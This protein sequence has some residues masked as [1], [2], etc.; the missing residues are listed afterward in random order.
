MNKE[1]VLLIQKKL[2]KKLLPLSQASSPYLYPPGTGFR[3]FSMFDV[4]DAIRELSDPVMSEEEFNEIA[5]GVSA[6]LQ[7]EIDSK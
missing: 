2:M 6:E 3:T 5:D 7:K 1:D 4:L